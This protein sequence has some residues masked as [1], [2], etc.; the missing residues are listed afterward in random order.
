MASQ[1]I[2][3]ISRSDL[4]GLP[5]ATGK[6]TGLQQLASYNWLEKPVP[7]ILVPGKVLLTTVLWTLFA[8]I[9]PKGSPPLWSPPLLPPKLTPDSGM[10]YNDENAARNPRF[11]L[12]PL[13]RA[14]YVENSDFQIGGIDLVTD[15]NNLRKLL[16]F[17]Q[18]SSNDAFQIRVE[19][20][21]NR[22]ALFTR[23]EAKPTDFIQGFRGYGRNF[24]KAYTTKEFGNST[25]H[26][27]VGYDFGGMNCIVRHETDG[28]VDNESPTQLAD[29]LS[30]ALKGLS[31]S[32]TDSIINDSAVTTVETG[33]RAVKLSST[34]ELKTRAASRNLDMAEA[35]SQLWISQT[36]KLVVGYY[37]NGV[38][39]N[40]HLRDM[41]NEIRKWEMTNQTDLGNLACLLAK[42][43]G[44]VKHSGDRNAVVKYDGG[45][46]LRIVPGDGKPAL[47]DD[48]YAKWEV[49]EQRD[50]DPT[51]V[52][53]GD[54]A[55]LKTKDEGSDTTSGQQRFEY[56]TTPLLIPDGT[57][58][59]D[60][61]DYAVHKGLRQFFRRMP[62]RL[63][64]YLVLC[65][66]LKSLPIDVLGGRR[67]RD[68]MDDMRQGKSQWDPG[69]GGEIE[70]LKSVA[71][72][73]AFRLLY[74][75]LVEEFTC[76]VKEQ[77]SAFNAALFVV[78][79]YRIF[80]YTTRKIV[81]AAFEDRFHVSAKQ[82]KTLNQWPIG[83]EDEA[84]DVT[85]EEECLNADFDSDFDSYYDS[86][87]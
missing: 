8:L 87:F 6:I 43:I 3:E 57:P 86:D 60:N 79:H 9:T 4:A 62:V 18:G 33:G 58:F 74:M 29:N 19:I 48:L 16:R 73:S 63:S 1:I 85:T 78:S 10:V 70:G 42:I 65:E 35:F 77:N 26:R 82:L 59:S 38:F 46:K 17:V 67:L 22:T 52:G 25:H 34:L 45:T 84:E 37:R 71:R 61:I 53:R 15:R 76:E 69:D 47:P 80:K 49:E 39:D 56:G 20:A 24:E 27:I 28:Y 31:I 72:D 54:V 7:T 44:V 32:K 36:P 55:K 68:I 64:D 81:R 83:S 14:L 75:F 30:D 51:Q 66:T 23:V 5:T 50:I 2:A 41:T 40:V 11:P 21:G 12:E 13:F